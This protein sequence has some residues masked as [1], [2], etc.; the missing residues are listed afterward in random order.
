MYTIQTLSGPSNEDAQCFGMNGHGGVAGV[1]FKPSL[2]GATWNGSQSPNF[3]M[4]ANSESLLYA[5][6]N[7]GHAA[8]LKG[9]NNSP[10]ARD[11]KMTT[12]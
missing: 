6:N 8:G 2:V 1:V 10:T 12:S 9:F 4:G 7:A 5:I 11:Y 3:Q